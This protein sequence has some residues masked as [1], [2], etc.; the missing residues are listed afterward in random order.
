MK[1][2]AKAMPHIYLQIAQ[3]E[4]EKSNLKTDHF[5]IG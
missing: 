3:V 2:I 1:K 5:K 4:I